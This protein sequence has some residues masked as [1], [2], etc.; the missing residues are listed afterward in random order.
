MLPSPHKLRQRVEDHLLPVYRNFW[1]Y[2]SEAASKT[3][4]AFDKSWARLSGV[5]H[6]FLHS[7]P[8]KA[9]NSA[10]TRSRLP[11]LD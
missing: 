11:K 3:P 8:G 5:L 7:N 1:P 2:A 6:D 4:P 9:E 10:A